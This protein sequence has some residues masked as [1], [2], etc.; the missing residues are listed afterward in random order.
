M[1][2]DGST[3][4]AEHNGRIVIKEFDGKTK[5]YADG[6]LAETLETGEIK[7]VS[8]ENAENI[9]VFSGI[10]CIPYEF[11]V[12]NGK[13]KTYADN[14]NAVMYVCGYENGKLAEV[15]TAALQN[16][17]FSADFSGKEKCFVFERESL[18]PLCDVFE[19]K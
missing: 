15:K 7:N 18:K 8:Y 9:S 1:C 3:H 6:V 5:I 11:Y 13:I 10:T 14:E 4:T 19:I 12:E 17:K 2:T 16:R